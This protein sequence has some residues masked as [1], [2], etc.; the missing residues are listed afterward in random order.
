MTN[1]DSFEMHPIRLRPWQ[2]MRATGRSKGRRSYIE[3]DLDEQDCS[4]P[5]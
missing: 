5:E 4:E 2:L 1:F 3:T